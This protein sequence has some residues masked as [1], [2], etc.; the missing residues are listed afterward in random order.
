MTSIRT[1]FYLFPIE[2]NHYN[3]DLTKT[4]DILIVDDTP[5]N[6][7][8]LSR[9]LTRQGYNVRKALNGAM[10]LTAAQTVAP[11]LILL[12]I[13]MPEMDGYEVCQNLKANAKTAE[14][15]VIFL[16]AL[17]DVLD[18]TVILNPRIH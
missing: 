10:A 13:M 15:P 16:S 14:I 5:D 9:M 11:D 2:M 1:P 4:E 6:L 3:L 17:D 8:L 12:D 7:H 18:L